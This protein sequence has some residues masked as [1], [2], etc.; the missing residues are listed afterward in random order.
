[1][2]Y[3]LT[4]MMT[5]GRAVRYSDTAAIAVTDHAALVLA[6]AGGIVIRD[7]QSLIV[8][9]ASLVATDTPAMANARK[10]RG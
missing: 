8:T 1:M 9:L 7:A 2:A 5:T 3:S 4:Y 6:G 10:P